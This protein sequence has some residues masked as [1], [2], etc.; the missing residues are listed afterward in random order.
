MQDLKITIIQSEIAWENPEKNINHFNKKI[1]EIDSDTDLIILPEVFNTGFPVDPNNFAETLNGKTVNRLR[2]KAA[3]KN[4][5]ITGSLLIEENKKF[6]NCLIWMQANGS[7]KTYKKRHV[8]QLG[9]ESDLISPGKEKLIVELKG[10]KI[11]PMICFD[12]RF[13]VWSKNQYINNKFEYDLLIYVA[14]W[15]AQRSYTW[16]QLLISRAI[17]NLSYVAGVNRVG[18]DGQGNNYSGNSAV[19]DPKGKIISNIIPGKEQ[20]ETIKLSYKNLESFRNDFNV[21]YDWDDFKILDRKG[22]D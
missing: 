7:F 19:I 15:P 10:W 8:F 2:Q 11:C 22:K 20:T 6:Y 21:G 17:E 16:K 4:C 5:V 14:N 13:P 1:D 9:D 18:T 3:E 12:L